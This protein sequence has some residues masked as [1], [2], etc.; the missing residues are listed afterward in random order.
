M[1]HV[2]LLRNPRPARVLY[3]V[4]ATVGRGGTNRRDDVFLVQFFL[5]ALWG[6][7]ADKDAGTFGGTG[8]APAIDGVCGPATIRAIELYQKWLWLEPTRG[9]VADGLVEPVPP[10]AV[11]FQTARGHRYTIAGLNINFGLTFGWDRHS[12]LSNEPN[13]PV[14][15][16]QKLFI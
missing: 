16:M 8:P 10:Q 1:A 3:L 5:N 4:D 2:K 14:E 15:L 6:K 9:S 11:N 12:V 13:F 7:L